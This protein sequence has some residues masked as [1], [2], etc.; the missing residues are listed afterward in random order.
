MDIAMPAQVLERPPSQDA[1]LRDASPEEHNFGL[2]V[3]W[4][5]VGGIAMVAASMVVYT[6]AV[7]WGGL[8]VGASIPGSGT[9]SIS[10]YASEFTGI[11]L[12]GF[13]VV[14]IARSLSS[15]RSR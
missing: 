15:A 11:F 14:L 5:I 6:L 3:A 9:P 2:D 4:A 1:L 8:H 7:T 10:A 12:A 13:L